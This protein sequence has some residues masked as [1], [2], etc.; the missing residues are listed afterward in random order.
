MTPERWQQIEALCQ[1]ALERSTDER[2]AFLLRAC[3]DDH[4]L[5][6]EVESLLAQYNEDPAF[7]E[8]PLVAILPGEPEQ[9]H[10]GPYR[11]IRPLGRGGMGQVFLASRMDEDFK[12]YVA[13]KVIRRGLDTEDILW[14]FRAERQ[15]LAALNHP[16]IARLYDGGTTEEGLPYF[17]MEYVEGE[18][19]TTYCDRH[20]LSIEARLQLFRQVCAAIQYAH[21]NLVVHRDLK[22]SNILVTPAGEVKL[23]DF[24]IAKLMSPGLAGFS[25]P[26]TRTEMRLMTPEYASPEQVRGEVITTATDVYALGVL[27]YELLTGRRPYRLPSRLRQ[28]I[29]RVICEEEPQRPSTAVTQVEDVTR[30]DE[31]TQT[32]TPEAVSQARGTQV[33]RLR[34]QLSGDLDNIVLMA[35]RKEPS[36]RYASVE[37]LAEDVRRHLD[38]LPVIAR[39][40]TFSYRAQ[41][42]VRRHRFGVASAAVIAVVLVGSTTG[43]VVQSAQVQAKSAEVAHERDRAEQVIEFLVDL[44]ETSDPNESKGETVTARELLDRASKELEQQLADQPEVQTQMKLVIG[45]VY[46]K[47]GLYDQATMLAS[48]ALALRRQVYGKQHEAVAEAL[49]NLASAYAKKA[50]YAEADSLYREALAMRRALF[51]EAHPSVAN[52]LSNLGVL[53]K[54]TG[55]LSEA[56]SLYQ[57]ALAMRRSLLGNEH[58]EV[59]LSLN[60]LA[61]LYTA[62]G[63]YDEAEALHREA[64]AIRRQVHDEGHLSIANSI[65]NI[66]TV[67]QAKGDYESAEPLY[68]EALAMF[69]KRLGPE[70]PDVATVRGNLAA[71]LTEQGK[72]EEAEPVYREILDVQRQVLGAEHPDVS[73]SLNNLASVL[74]KKGDYESAE[75]L[76]RKALT[77]QMQ[78][79]GPDHPNTAAMQHNLAGVLYEKGDEREAER[80]FREALTTFE[81]LLGAAHPNVAVVKSGLADVL[82]DANASEAERLYREALGVFETVFPENHAHTVAAQVGL[83]VALI[84]LDKA[85]QAERLLQEALHVRQERFGEND[86]YTA[87][88]KM[89]LGQC[90]ARLT[91]FDEAEPLLRESQAVLLAERG[92]EHRLVREVSV[93]LD[94]LYRAWGKPVPTHP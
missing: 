77:L 91:R 43:M 54:N 16:H 60:N 63:R 45:R 26:M 12:H 53:L 58:P 41:K 38:G 19:I 61:T 6:K 89:A 82:R 37:Q 47:L 5:Q 70:H 84:R 51:G 18:P 31:T 27:L 85:D 73:I 29:E 52:T 25:V 78:L 80:Y 1:E 23:L 13:L 10:I 69:F 40:D 30:E 28:E 56:D 22:P 59:A 49:H 72:Y 50:A 87:E 93:A 57:E 39:P 11:L 15:I 44:F 7:L 67:L 62:Q 86:W 3:A 66:A 92:P 79:L 71:V 64:L 8:E 94:Q 24:G 33:E 48:Q 76:F 9:Q 65:N 32:L 34:R 75:P 2:A 81:G 46:E 55:K 35:M 20:R 42:F 74:R 17:V 4:D 14:R 36:R 83:G 90:L 21:Q 68:R 88:A